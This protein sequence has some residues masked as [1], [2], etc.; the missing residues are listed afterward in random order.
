M[1]YIRHHKC[2]PDWDPNLV[3]CLYGPD[4]DLVFLALATHEPHFMLLRP[5]CIHSRYLST[6]TLKLSLLFQRER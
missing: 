6:L 4:A 2:Q 3:H 5:G 1:D